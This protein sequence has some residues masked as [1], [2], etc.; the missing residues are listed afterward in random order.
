MI[1]LRSG[2][3]DPY[4][5]LLNHQSRLAGN[6]YGATCSFVGTLRDFN[7]GVSVEGMYLE[8]YPGMTEK[9]LQRIVQEATER[10]PCEDILLIHR[11]GDISR[12]AAIVLIAVW[13][14]HRGAAFD[15]CRYIIEALKSRAPFWKRETLTGSSSRWVDKNTDGYCKQP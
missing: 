3:F 13:S 6:A 7:E 15:A 2:D 10:W 4:A 12:N 5:E 1:E 14:A 9:F 8:H 11:T